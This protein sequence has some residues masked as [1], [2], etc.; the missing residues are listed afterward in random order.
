MNQFTAKYAIYYKNQGYINPNIKLSNGLYPIEFAIWIDDNE[1]L[2]GIAKN[3]DN[4]ILFNAILF[5]LKYNNISRSVK[6]LSYLNLSSLP[7]TKIYKLYKTMNDYLK[8][9]KFIIF[10]DDIIKKI[11]PN[12]NNLKYIHNKK[13]YANL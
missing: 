10:Y 1:N 3:T 11:G 8:G 12:H 2:E 5:S 13:L 9:D 6:L 4:N 7:D